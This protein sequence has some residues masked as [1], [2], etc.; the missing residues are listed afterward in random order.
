MTMRGTKQE[1]DI[2]CNDPRND[3]S[4]GSPHCKVEAD[5]TL[6]ATSS[7]IPELMGCR[8]IVEHASRRRCC[9][10]L[11]DRRYM[12]KYIFVSAAAKL[13]VGLQKAGVWQCSD[14]NSGDA[15]S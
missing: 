12:Y 13:E 11:V 14:K 10:V 2:L 1:T 7:T 5:T 9:P 15:Q 3:K 8:A 6:F 4:C